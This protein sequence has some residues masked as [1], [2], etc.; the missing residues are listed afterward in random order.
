MNPKI[1]WIDMDGTLLGA[2]QVAI[3][4]RNMAALHALHE[5]GVCVVPCTGRVV[6]MLPPQVLALPWIRYVVSSH[7]ARVY[8]RLKQKSLYENVLPPTDSAHVLRAFEGRGLY[9]EVAAAHTIYIEQETLAQLTCPPVPSHHVW[10]MCRQKAFT[11]VA[12][13]SEY[14]LQN[15]L[16]IE[17]VNLYGIP[18]AQQKEVYDAITATGLIRHTRGAAARDLE[19]SGASLDKPAALNA[20]LS[21]LGASY[22]DVF[23]IGDSSTDIDAI[24]LACVGVAM[25]NAPEAIQN[26]ADYVTATNTQ[27]GFALAVERFFDRA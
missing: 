18:D 8:D 3:S 17:K 16:G 1:A 24:R 14:F 21:H 10:Y 20:L 2:D 15:G 12:S 11:A 23:A 22:D 7:G 26:A 6:D 13:L 5:C 25:G 9:A 19:F 27:D 4:P